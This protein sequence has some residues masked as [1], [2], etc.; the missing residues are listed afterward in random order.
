[1]SLDDDTVNKQKY[2]GNDYGQHSKETKA[3]AF[4]AKRKP[5]LED[6]LYNIRLS[7]KYGMTRESSADS[8]NRGV[9][10]VCKAILALIA[11]G[12]I[13]ETNRRRKTRHGSTAV[14][15]VAR[16]F[17]DESSAI[18]DPIPATL[19]IDS[20]TPPP[21]TSL[22]TFDRS[23]AWQDCY[24]R[25]KSKLVETKTIITESDIEELESKARA[26]VERL[27]AWHK[28]KNGGAM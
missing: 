27:E 5:L 8:T 26:M 1:M 28:R 4:K 22:E 15:L 17:A 7:E 10:C 11:D 14:V 20:T 6:L 3:A 13:V 18:V 21:T 25:L 9:Q 16:E 24:M 19:P 23:T 2:F 12:L